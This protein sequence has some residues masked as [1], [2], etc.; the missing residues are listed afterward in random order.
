MDPSQFISYIDPSF[1][2]RFLMLFNASDQ[3]ERDALKMVLHRLY[4]KFVQQRP[5]IRQAIQHIFYTYIYETRYFSGI[6]ELL[7]IM[8]SIIN[9]Y[10]V[11][12][13][14]EHI[15]FLKNILLPLHTSYYLHL[16]H[17]NLFFCVMQYVQ[18]DP[19]LIPMVIK[20]LLRLWPIWCSLKELLFITNIGKLVDMAS[21]EQ[22]VGLSVPLFHKIGQCITSNNF[23]VS[24]AGML[25]WK[26]DRFVQFTTVHAKDLFPIIC[27]YLY[28]TGTNHWNT[29]IKN[30]AVSVIRICMETSPAVFEAFSKTM[31]AQEQVE[32]ERMTMQKST[33]K[34]VLGSASTADSHVVLDEKIGKL[35]DVYPDPK[36]VTE[37][38]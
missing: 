37:K 22:F 7:E 11:P 27:P 36:A 6:T 29:A 17:S 19:S 25:L 28:K 38:K 33:W 35:E 20:E 26:N 32:M 30:L 34:M 12:L 15:D 31:K 2:A 21:E 24:E 14:Q 18:K 9:G 1:I 13:K 16:F 23:Q 8:I 4:L 10:A 3:R 5:L